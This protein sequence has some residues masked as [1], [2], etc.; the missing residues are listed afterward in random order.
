MKRSKKAISVPSSTSTT[1]NNKKN[2]PPTSGGQAAPLTYDPDVLQMIN[3]NA[4]GIDVASE[5][6]WV[7]VPADRATPNVRRFGAFTADLEALADWLRQC[8]ITSVAMESTGVYWIPLYQILVERGFE[9]CLTNA[10]HLKNVSG[11]PKSDRLDCQWIQRLHSYG[12][13]KASFR[14]TDAICQLRSIQ[15][16][17][18]TLIH[19]N[20]RHIQH[21]QKALHQMNV[22]LPKVVAD[23]TGATGLAIIQQILDGERNPVK[24]A[25]LRNPH[26]QSS[27][28]EIAQALYGDYRREHLFVLRQ[29]H[30]A[31]QFVQGQ[32]RECDRELERLVAEVDKQ[33][34]ANQTPPPPREKT[35][36]PL[37]RNDVQFAVH[38]GRTLLY[39]CFGVD[40]TRIPG[41]EVSSALTLFTEVGANLTPWPSAKHFT[42]YL[43]LAPNV[44]SSA[45]KVRSSQTRKVASRAAGVF[46]LAAQAVIRSKT[47][48]GA[49][50]RRMK[51]RLG[52]SKALTA[53]AR[54][55]AVIFYH[56]VTAHVP[57]HELGETGYAKQQQART[58]KRLKQQAKHLGYTLVAQPA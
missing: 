11:R 52:G 55:I 35:P 36:Q 51:A 18:D 34:D 32:I 22:L 41:L 14:P 48:L 58:L 50:Y 26:C 6:M 57:Y 21:M 12:F 29:A 37:H 24:L 46:R 38:D 40:V 2:T 16:H 9:V 20:V 49:F 44:Q 28:D 1:T 53:T 7:C 39:A 8:R 23:I 56:M 17:R 31:F 5:E 25:R 30:T 43:G 27:E 42:S 3:P 45:G 47:A 33:V 15:R 4:A 10:R 13:L 54:K 19:E